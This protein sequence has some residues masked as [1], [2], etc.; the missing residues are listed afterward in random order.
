MNEMFLARGKLKYDNLPHK[1]GDWVYGNY[2][3]LKDGN[4]TMCCIYGYGEII[5]E[6]VGR[7][8]GKLDKNGKRIFEGDIVEYN[9][10]KHEVIFETRFSAYFGIKISHVETWQFCLEVPAKL[11]EVVGNIYDNPKL[12]GGKENG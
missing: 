9:G 10:T 6:T 7:Y 8:I 4:R 5:P 12:I 11:M 2:V 1:K 3:E